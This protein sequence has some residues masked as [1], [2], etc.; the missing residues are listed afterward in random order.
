MSEPIYHHYVSNFYLKK[1][2]RRAGAY[3]K[4]NEFD[5]TTGK[6]NPKR[7]TDKTGGSDHF[8]R[9]F[10]PTD[11][12]DVEKLY[13]RIIETP[14]GVAFKQ[15]LNAGEF[16]SSDDLS[17]VLLF[18]AM[19]TA[20]N[21]K[22]R[23]RIEA[24]TR[25]LDALL[26]R[27][28]L[29]DD[30]EEMLRKRLG[31]NLFPQEHVEMEF[32]QIDNIWQSLTSKSWVILE[33]TS[34]IGEFIT[35]DDPL[36][37]VHADEVKPWG[38]ESNNATIYAPLSPTLA[39][40][41]QSSKPKFLKTTL[42]QEQVAKLNFGTMVSAYQHVYYKSDNFYVFQYNQN[43]LMKWSRELANRYSTASR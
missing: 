12:N 5:K 26:I 17:H 8:N 30:G 22:W 35:C 15:M 34:E 38:F 14:A 6:I 9:S 4:I 27:T 21:P 11:P 7:R 3:F 19:T 36:Q 37:I 43:K 1:F 2:A 41:G 13:A 16:T 32:P 25:T 33:T 23:S 18:F 28:A 29:G 42:D 31:R 40:L 24:P 10:S 39:I 20:R